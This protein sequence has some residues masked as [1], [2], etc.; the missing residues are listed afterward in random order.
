MVRKI[1]GNEPTSVDDALY[2][3]ARGKLPTPAGV[4]NREQ[5]IE[6][7]EETYGD[8]ASSDDDES[9]DALSVDELKDELKAREL[10]TSGNK[11]DLVARLEEDDEASDD[12]DE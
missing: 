3:H 5:L 9:Y 12:G 7:F 11:K 2:L 8:G 4:N 10:S 1:E 6:S